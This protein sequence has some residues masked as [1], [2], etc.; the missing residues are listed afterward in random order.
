MKVI[1]NLIINIHPLDFLAMNNGAGLYI[2]LI[3]WFKI[4]PDVL[5]EGTLDRLNN[6]PI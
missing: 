4:D 6:L 2:T 5:K 1:K 3:N